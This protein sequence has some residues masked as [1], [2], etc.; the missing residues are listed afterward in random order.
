MSFV[1][2]MDQ[3]NEDYRAEVSDAGLQKDL[4]TAI[5]GKR[6]DKRFCYSLLASTGICTVPL[7]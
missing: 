5:A 4:D 6:F 3:M 7:S 2:R 1:F